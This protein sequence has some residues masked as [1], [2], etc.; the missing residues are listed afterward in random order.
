MNDSFFAVENPECDVSWE[1]AIIYIIQNYA[2]VDRYVELGVKNSERFDV[3]LALDKLKKI[4]IQ[5]SYSNT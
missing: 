2:L 4:L 3:S 5:L 1:N